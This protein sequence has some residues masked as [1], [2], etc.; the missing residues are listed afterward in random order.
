MS[1]L[2]DK[3]EVGPEPEVD[4]QDLL[5]LREG[6]V[7]NLLHRVMTVVAAAPGMEDTLKDHSYIRK[8]LFCINRN[9]YTNFSSKM[10][11]TS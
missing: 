9:I 11:P 5:L 6:K 10:F 1:N 2:E 7:D 8:V 4:T 3:L